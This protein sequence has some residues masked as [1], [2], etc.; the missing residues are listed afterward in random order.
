M[1][2]QWNLAIGNRVCDVVAHSATDHVYVA[3]DDCVLV[4]GGY[5]IKAR[6]PVGPDTKRLILCADETYL[7]VF[8][9]DGSVRVIS[10]ADHAMTTIPGSPSSAEVVSP[11]GRFLYT[12]HPAACVDST[13]SQISAKAADGTLLGTVA[14]KNYATGMDVS[15]DG[16]RLYVATSTVS[17]HTQ[18]F[19]GWVTVIDTAQ[20][21][22][23]DSIAVPV[24]PDTVTVSPDGSRVFVTHYDT[25]SISAIDVERRSV[26]SVYLPDAP[27]SAVTT[28]DGGVYVICVQSLVAVDFLTRAAEPIPAGHMPRRIQFSP[29]GERACITDLGSSSVAVLD[30][31]TNSVIAVVELDGHP[32]ALTL[33]GSGEWLY[34]ADYWAGMLSVIS[35]PSVLPDAEAA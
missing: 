8:S 35:M 27:I 9:Y 6:I 17:T 28:P 34:V 4:M 1:A 31:I 14:I 33:N 18:F 20:H 24:S 2:L 30:T 32:E 23:I 10:I 5:N 29:D 19:P 7:Y 22:V 12:A 21:A 3:V 13:Y 15:P 16:G 11:D 25:N 26:A